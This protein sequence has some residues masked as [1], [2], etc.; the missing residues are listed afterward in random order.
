M[1]DLLFESAH[2]EYSRG[3]S[4]GVLEQVRFAFSELGDEAAAIGATRIAALAI[5]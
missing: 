3:V 4:S 2:Q 1:P 5:R